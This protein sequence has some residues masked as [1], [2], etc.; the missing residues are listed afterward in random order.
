MN[1]KHIILL[2]SLLVITSNAFAHHVLGR[3]SYSLGEDSNTPPSMQVETQLGDFYITYM[4]FPAFPKPG[5]YGRVNLYV[6]R[7]DNGATFDGKVTFKVSDDS[8]FSSTSEFLGVQKIDDGVYRQGF[9][10]KEQGD[11]LITAE[12]ESGGQPYIIDF[13]LQIGEPFPIGPIGFSI[14][15]I[16]LVLVF[17]NVTQ[18]KRLSRIKANQHHSDQ[19]NDSGS[20]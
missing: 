10:F 14:F 17:V 13:P 6:K 15:F 7:I 8:F 5:D 9:V 18:R 4:A 12:F 20:I 16:A 19:A 11:F 2:T 3:P 1:I